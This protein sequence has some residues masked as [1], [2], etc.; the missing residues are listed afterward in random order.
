MCQGSHPKTTRGHTV[1]GS[2]GLPFS[3]R[4]V[5]ASLS[6]IDVWRG[7]AWRGEGA[8]V[9]LLRGVRPEKWRLGGIALLRPTP[10]PVCDGAPPRHIWSQV[11]YKEEEESATLPDAG[12]V[13]PCHP[14]V[15]SQSIHAILRRPPIPRAARNVCHDGMGERGLG[16]EGAFQPSCGWFR[17]K[18]VSNEGDRTYWERRAPSSA[19][20]VGSRERQEGLKQASP[21]APKRAAPPP[22]PPVQVHPATRPSHDNLECTTPSTPHSTCSS[23]SIPLQA[24]VRSGGPLPIQGGR[25][26]TSSTCRWHV[27]SPYVTLADRR[28]SAQRRRFVRASPLRPFRFFLAHPR[29]DSPRPRCSFGRE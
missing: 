28:L 18:P 17:W 16:H 7:V 4:L 10:S 9:P 15:V 2:R 24:V 14:R 11:T 23:V 3:S 5:V 29:V 12:P 22:P 26:A 25:R 13:C 6:V 27:T 20:V 8:R 21:K 1:F 19:S